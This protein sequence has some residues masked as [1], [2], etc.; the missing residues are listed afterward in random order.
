MSKAS[1]PWVIKFGGSLAGSKALGQGI[2]ALVPL[3]AIIVP[4]GGPFADAI[5]VCQMQLGFDDRV[6][7]PLA[8][9]A[10]G[11]YGQMLHGIEPRLG[12]ATAIAH[13]RDQGERD[14]AI[15]WLPDPDE[16]CLSSLE[17][18][19]NVTSDTLAVHLALALG[20]PQVLLMK[21]L[22]SQPGD[23]S[24]QDA[25]DQG[26]IDQALPERVKGSTLKLWRIGPQG[27][28]GLAKGLENPVSWFT[29]M[30]F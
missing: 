23:E 9:Q 26:I 22:D 20:V 30:V 2:A 10:M 19:W 8:I 6:A 4:G 28:E 24:L 1:I 29:R 18:S 5:R 13:L 16:P 25:S 12:R 7:H 15:V 14:Q 3:R 27:F 11:L 17:A 21:S